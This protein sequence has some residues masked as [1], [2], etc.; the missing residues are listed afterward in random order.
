MVVPHGDSEQPKRRERVAA[1]CRELPRVQGVGVGFMGSH[2]ESSDEKEGSHSFG[3]N[4]RDVRVML[5]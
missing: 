3:L 4:L 2:W 1:S 5:Q